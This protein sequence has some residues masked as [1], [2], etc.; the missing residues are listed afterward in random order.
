MRCAEPVK[1]IEILRLSEKG[2]SQ[3]QIAASVKCAKSTVGE[4]QRRCREQGLTYSQAGDMTNDAIK[5]LL[6]PANTLRNSSKP[7]PDWEKIDASLSGRNRLNRQFIWEEYRG[8]HPD[9]LGYSQFC[10]RYDQWRN[11]TG[12]DVV[13]AREREPG[14]EMF[15]DWMGDTLGCVLDCATGELLEAHFFVA[16]LGDSSYPY[17]EAFPNEKSDKWLMGH[18]HAFEWV[19][20]VPKIIIPDNLKSAVTRANYYDP[21]LNPA[22]WQLAKHYEVAVIPAR[23][24]HPKDKSPAE[25]SIGWLETWLLEWLRGKQFFSFEELNTAIRVRVKELTKR[26]Y[27]KRPGTREEVFNKIDRPA[28]R[29]LPVAR[30]EHAEYVLRRVPDNYHVEYDGFYYSV[31]FA[32]H[33]QQVTLRVSSETIEVINTNRERVALH[34]RRFVGSRYVTLRNHMPK[35]HQHQHDMERFDGSKY[36]NWAKNIGENT[37]FVINT[38]LTAQHVEETAYRSCMGALQM[39]SKYGNDRLE[40][41]CGKARAM[42]SCT[43][44]TIK[45]ILKNA[46]D[47]TPAPSVAKPTPPH[48]NIRGPASFV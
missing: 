36:R 13:M 39:G 17:V 6:Y 44:T 1:I 9:G 28:L 18:V 34:Q 19:G 43:Y 41:A 40:T 48:E 2:Y 47:K 21:K 26:P 3:R 14:R 12:K 30:Y 46:Q 8:S 16:V 37:A 25:S 10:R 35:N 20:G 22:Y 29:P 33:K 45:N 11:V 5:A 42:N 4:V 32:M 23:I 15:V 24:K 31:P 27:Q 38:M 7:E